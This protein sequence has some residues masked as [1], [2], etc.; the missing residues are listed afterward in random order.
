MKLRLEKKQTPAAGDPSGYAVFNINT[1]L[2]EYLPDWQEMLEVKE[3][4]KTLR[5]QIE[6]QGVKNLSAKVSVSASYTNTIT[7]T[8]EAWVRLW[9]KTGNQTLEEIKD[10]GAQPRINWQ[11]FAVKNGAA[12]SSSFSFD[13]GLDDLDKNYL[14]EVELRLPL[15]QGENYSILEVKQGGEFKLNQVSATVAANVTIEKDLPWSKK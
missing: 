9:E 7:S 2:D 5:Q 8:A 10:S 12:T 6:D 1:F 4:G 14:A 3:D 13:A 15:V 11:R